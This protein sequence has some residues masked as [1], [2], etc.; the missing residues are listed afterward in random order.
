MWQSPLR[1]GCVCGSFLK[2]IKLARARL[3]YAELSSTNYLFPLRVAFG[4]FMSTHMPWRTRKKTSHEWALCR[5]SSRVTAKS[6]GWV[7]ITGIWQAADGLVLWK[8][9]LPRFFSFQELAK[10]NL[11]SITGDLSEGDVSC[12]II[13]LL[14]SQMISSFLSPE[15][16]L[17]LTTP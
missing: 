15:E 3:D 1:G 17:V 5:F 2:W 7:P 14:K 12:T 4:Q 6:K 13:K 10:K 9:M 8:Q 16:M 11:D